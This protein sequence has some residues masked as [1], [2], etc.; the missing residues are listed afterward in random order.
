MPQIQLEDLKK[1]N[2]SLQEC[3]DESSAVTSPPIGKLVTMENFRLSDDGNRIEKRDGTT[4][5]VGP[6]TIG[7]KDVFGYHTYYDSTPA[8]CQLA[9]TEEKVWRK[10]GAASWGSIHT[11]ASTLAHPVKV[12]EIQGK[13][14]IVTEIENIQILADGNKRTLGITAPATAPTFSAAATVQTLDE[15]CAVIT[16]WADE[17]VG[18]GESTQATFLTLSCMKL[19]TAGGATDL[20]KRSRTITGLGDLYTLEFK[21]YF[22]DIGIYPDDDHFQ[23]NIYN[24]RIKMSLR[25]SEGG[26]HFE[27]EDH[28]IHPEHLEMSAQW[29]V[30]EDQWYT[31]K[32]LVDT[33]DPTDYHAEVYIDG[34]YMGRVDCADED[35]SNPGLVEIELYGQS[36]ATVVYVDYI[37]VSP[38][39]LDHLNG[40]YR[41]AVTYRRGG[42]YPCESNPIK[43]IVGTATYTKSNGTELDDLTPGGTYTGAEDK[44]IR[45]EIDG[46]GTPDTLKWSDDAGHT[47][48]SITLEL[49][50]TMYLPFGIELTWGATTGHTSGDYWDFD[51][52]A[53]SIEA[54]HEKVTLTSIPTSSDGQV[55]QRRI[56]RSVAGGAAFYLVATLN[57]NTTE[58]FVDNIPDSMLGMA[59]AEDNDVPPLGLYSEWFDDRLWIADADENIVYYSKTNV[60]DAFD[61]SDRYIS[62]RK[63]ELQDKVRGIKSFRSQLYIFKRNSALY[64][65]KKPTGAYGR[66]ECQGSH[67]VLAPWSIQEIYGLLTMVTFR[68]WENFNGQEPHPEMF[69][70]PLITTLKTIDRSEIDYI[71]SGHLRSRNEVW[72]SLPDRTGSASATICVVNYLR[73]K[74]YTFPYAKTVSYLGTA[75]DTNDDEQL[76]VGTRDGYIGTADSG[77]QDFS[78]NYTATA[79]TGW[80]KFPI[81]SGFRHLEI[82]YECLTGKNLDIDTYKD[83]DKDSIG[84]RVLAGATPTS[85][86]QSIRMPIK[87]DPNK[88][89]FAVECRYLALKLVNDEQIG[90]DFKINSVDGWFKPKAFK[91]EIKGD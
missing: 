1:F 76:I 10:V 30:K 77:N 55:T 8:F 25:L 28:W 18:G 21:A 14:I 84:Q 80:I 91:G 75:I 7:A 63:G 47:W 45:V 90:K 16:D 71:T 23:L 13:Q 6:S 19:L 73:N 86:D 59:M 88:L 78:A 24:G 89:S 62:A 60:P 83:F 82:E 54:L 31:F 58:T 35:T 64:V 51:C 3:A 36:N 79:R 42:N 66:Y 11:W 22:D 38:G 48:K 27:N 43:A 12:Y 49:S 20:A 74:L 44:T 61:T 41:Y 34:G 67:G 9:I 37:K 87:A 72:L 57:N 40:K 26:M 29:T 4:E 39:T 52:D 33:G 32:I 53:L 70:M 50:T 81:N 56:Y 46:T 2:I 15:D 69:S 85:T 17:D 68:G 5:I 65:R